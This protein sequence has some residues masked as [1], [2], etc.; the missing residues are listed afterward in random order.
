M[1]TLV[2]ALLMVDQIVADAALAPFQPTH[3]RV[4]SAHA[5][6]TA[7]YWRDFLALMAFTLYHPAGT[8]K[9]GRVGGH[10]EWGTFEA[11]EV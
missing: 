6:G 4:P 10:G 7:E 8:C 1:D 5:P 9:V 2:A 3:A 11:C